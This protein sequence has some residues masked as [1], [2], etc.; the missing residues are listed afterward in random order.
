KAT[1]DNRGRTVIS[2]ASERR[3]ASRNGGCTCA[4]GQPTGV[5]HCDGYHISSSVSSERGRYGTGTVST[6]EFRAEAV[7]LRA[8]V[9]AAEFREQLSCFKYCITHIVSSECSSQSAR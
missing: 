2:A 9:S 6:T 3:A 5:Q 7:T 8:A 4:A 1:S